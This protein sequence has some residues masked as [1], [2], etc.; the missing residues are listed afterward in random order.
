MFKTAKISIIFSLLIFILVLP[1]FAEDKRGFDA[2]TDLKIGPVFKIG[3]P[4]STN[5]NINYLPSF[6]LDI[7]GE[8]LLYGTTGF[9][10]NWLSSTRNF[11]TLEPG[12]TT[13]S[14]ASPNGSTKLTKHLLQ[15]TLI[16]PV[17]YNSDS[18]FEF[19][20]M[21]GIFSQYVTLDVPISGDT[22]SN[23]GIN[24][25]SY[26]RAYHFYPFVPSV[27]LKFIFGN[28]YDNGKTF[29]DKVLSSTLKLGF[30]LN[31][32]M[33]FYLTK[34][35]II[36]FSYNFN[37]PDFFYFAPTKTTK[38]VNGTEAKEPADDLL[39]NFA[40]STHLINGSIGF[41]F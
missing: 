2:K 32:G 16:S 30:F 38:A 18:N 25:G 11:V 3:F 23:I 36:S 19:G 21:G 12:K 31:G 29:Q 26:A 9:I 13:F 39:F 14:E 28:L 27:N 5:P 1:V 40:E 8:S 7:H 41:L 6:T 15:L 20:W 37:N 35:V 34:R 24:L 4:L 33:D 22:G 17:N 10:F